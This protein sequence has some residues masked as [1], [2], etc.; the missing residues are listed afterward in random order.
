MTIK[1]TSFSGCALHLAPKMRNTESD[2][3]CNRVAACDEDGAQGAFTS[4]RQRAAKREALD[5]AIRTRKVAVQAVRAV[6]QH[7]HRGFERHPGSMALQG[8]R[9]E[10]TRLQ[11]RFETTSTRKRLPLSF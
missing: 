10:Q 2:C 6:V 5:D 8:G 11:R 7:N 1:P 9:V 3:A 4:V